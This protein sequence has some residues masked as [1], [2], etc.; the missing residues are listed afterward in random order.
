MLEHVKITGF[1]HCKQ[2]EPFWKRRILRDIS[3]LRKDLSRI[4]T[5]FVGR[6]KKDKNQ[7]KN[8]LDQNYGLR[9]KGFTLIIEEQE[10]RITAKATKVKRYDNRIKQFQDNRNF[11]TNQGRFF[12]NIEGKEDRTKPQNAEDATAF[13]KGIW[14]TKVDHKRDAGWIDRAKENMPSRKQNTVKITKDDVKRKLL[15]S[16]LDWKG[17]GPDKIQCFWLKSLQLYMKF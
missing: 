5:W 13:W 2:K 9:K 11:Q 3:R 17:S 16:M 14:S 6:W 10:Q 12:K 1:T 8:L 4:E 15:K 7:Q